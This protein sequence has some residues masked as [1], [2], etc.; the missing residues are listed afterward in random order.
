MLAHNGRGIAIKVRE[1]QVAGNMVIFS[2]SQGDETAYPYTDKSHG[3]FTYFLLKKI[4]ETG[5]DISY[6]EL[7]EYITSQVSK[8]SIVLN[9][10]S[11]TPKVNPSYKIL[12]TWENW[13]LV[14]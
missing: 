14:E 7:G 4:Q 1:D 3:M 10:K 8:K 11:Q 9:G 6:K 12:N 2:A 13:S 5:G